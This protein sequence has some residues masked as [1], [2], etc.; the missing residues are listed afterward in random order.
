MHYTDIQTQIQH[1][2]SYQAAGM[3]IHLVQGESPEKL[4]D[5]FLCVGGKQSDGK[6]FDQVLI[7]DLITAV[8]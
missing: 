7:H 6:K 1:A 3:I 8:M 2:T 4:C 5:F